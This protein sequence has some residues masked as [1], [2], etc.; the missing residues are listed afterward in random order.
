MTYKQISTIFSALEAEDKMAFNKLC[1]AN[2]V[3]QN[4][5][6]DAYDDEGFDELCKRVDDFWTN[7]DCSVDLD[8]FCY[9][10]SETLARYNECFVNNDIMN[11]AYNLAMDMASQRL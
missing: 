6:L 10:I 8:D 7:R 9:A 5:D 3:K 1:V 2:A 11:I 4:I